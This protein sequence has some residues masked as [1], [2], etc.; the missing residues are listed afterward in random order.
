MSTI[1]TYL[2]T[3]FDI[4]YSTEV[5]IFGHSIGLYFCCLE[6]GRHVHW[7]LIC[8]KSCSSKLY[9]EYHKSC[10]WL[11]LRH[12]K[13]HYCFHCLQIACRGNL[14]I[15]RLIRSWWNGLTTPQLDFFTFPTLSNEVCLC[16][17]LAKE[18]WIN[19]SH[20]KFHY[21]R[22]FIPYMRSAKNKTYYFWAT[23]P[24]TIKEKGQTHL[25]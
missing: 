6:L 24:K 20:S 14:I 21:Q 12:D 16:Q 9:N 3:F 17:H 25:R 15:L 19:I 8:P 1:W 7:Y 22:D 5:G 4:L 23:V 10:D 11:W 2:H 13:P 18:W